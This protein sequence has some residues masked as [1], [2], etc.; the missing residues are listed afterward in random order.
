MILLVIFYQNLA[1]FIWSFVG[2]QVS[3]NLSKLIPNVHQSWETNSTH[4][5]NNRAEHMKQ[6]LNIH[7]SDEPNARVFQRNLMAKSQE[8]LLFLIS[9]YAILQL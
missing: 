1:D 2:Y 4:S 3:I 7:T 5:E 6:K 8:Q 9:K